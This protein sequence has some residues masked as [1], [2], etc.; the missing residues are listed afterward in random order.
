MS[1]STRA[2]RSSSWESELRFELRWVEITVNAPIISTFYTGLNLASTSAPTAPDNPGSCSGS[3]ARR[4][5]GSSYF[6]P[7]PEGSRAVRIR[8]SSGSLAQRNVPMFLLITTQFLAFW[9]LGPI[10]ISRK[11]ISIVFFNSFLSGVALK[12]HS[13]RGHLLYNTLFRC[14][15]LTNPAQIL[16]DKVAMSLRN[17]T[18]NEDILKIFQKSHIQTGP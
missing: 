7:D 17:F 11:C 5:S 16:M 14:G 15:I 1:S 9:G 2:S 12:K 10:Q 18:L 4:G 8:G 3:A 13:S 6:G